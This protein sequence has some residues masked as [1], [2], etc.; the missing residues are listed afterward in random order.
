MICAVIQI[1]AFIGVVVTAWPI[2]GFQQ[3]VAH[4]PMRNVQAM[5]PAGDMVW[6][7]T[8]GGV[9]SYHTVS[10]EIGRYDVTDG[11]YDVQ[12]QVISY[13]AGRNVVWMG[14]VDG[15]LDALDVAS[16][17]ITTFFDIHR[18]TRFPSPE[19]LRLAV[20][21]D[22]L[23]AATSFGL[24]VFDLDRR[25]VRDT[26]SQFGTLAAGSAVRDLMIAA[27]PD[28]SRGLW[29]ALE[30]GLAFAA[31]STVNLQDPDSW[32][33]E[34]TVRPSRSLEAI[35]MFGRIV[36][37][38]TDRGLGRRT[39][40]GTYEIVDG[41][42]ARPITDLAVLSDRLLAIDAFKL[43]AVRE[44]GTT[45]VLADGYLGLQSVVAEADGMAWVADSE[46]GINQYVV[47][48]GTQRAELRM[49]DIFPGGPFDSPFGDLA[50]DAAGG[51]WATA[52]ESVEE[53]G[54]YHMAA[55]GTWTNFSSRFNEELGDHGNFLQVHVDPSGNS[56]VASR[57]SG[58]AV[59][60]SDG[61]LEVYDQDNSSLLPAAGTSGFVIV[62]GVG[63][64]QDGGVW[65][66]NTTASRPLHFRTRDGEWTSLPA[67]DCS[68]TP[69]TTAF[70]DLLVDSSGLLWILVQDIGN[71][72][73]TRGIVVLDTNDTPGDPTDDI[74][75]FIGREGA[76]GRGLPSVRI[77]SV[78]EDRVGRIWV[79]TDEGPAF[80]VAGAGA[81]SDPSLEAS[82]PIWSSRQEA[83]YVLHDLPV[84]GITTDPSN[85]L[86]MATR[87]GAYLVEETNNFDLVHRFTTRSSPILSNVVN[88][89]AVDGASGRVFI[90]TDRGL[91]TYDGDAIDPVEN[92]QRLFI[93]PNPVVIAGDADPDIYI[94]GLIKETDIRIM[95]VSGEL[96]G[97]IAGSGGRARWNARDEDGRL[98]P[99]GT[100]IV[101]AVGRNGE[102]TAFGKVAII[103]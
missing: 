89:I 49:G 13:D 33:V 41:L 39:S 19:I 43:Y 5:V 50:V 51:I 10:G 78:A 63:S 103:R 92:V 64:N 31:L 69:P 99:S 28:D 6:A 45:V 72:R 7:A 65:V 100:Y 8:S 15:V 37:V 60:R 9:F 12:P 70:G 97:Q 86:W 74:C 77:H 85:R 18:S 73:L 40:A 98:V 48:D 82:W 22:S 34:Q 95:S 53:G 71:L 76:L 47:R 62:G 42:P 21:G 3:W 88:T 75:Q 16:G 1:L 54:F 91:V 93:Y 25:E 4:T 26:Y 38:G 46:R 79:T 35:D 80:F 96:V 27:L 57:G 67:P 81:A 24:V 84:V 2:Y 68:G 23:L 30:G 94:E 55:D 14:Y 102:G 36:Y 17:S 32:T 59:V 56:W 66:T 29:L 83:S 101:A 20:L 61:E 90:S 58:L 11:L 87:E 44:G 52:V